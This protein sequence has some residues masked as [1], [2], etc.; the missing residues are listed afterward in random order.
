MK[1]EL[2]SIELFAGAGGLAIGLE[3]AGF[4]SKGVFEF[5]KHACATLRHNRPAWNVV[6]G[7]VSEVDF[8]PY[9]GVD[10]VVGGV[11]CQAFSYAGKR[12]GFGDTRG[13]LFWQFA[14]AIRETRPR[15]F[16]MENV[17]G[18]VSH[19]GGRTLKTMIAE[20]TKIGYEVCEPHILN[21]LHHSVPQKRERLILVGFLPGLG[22]SFSAPIPSDVRLTLRDTLKAGCLYPTDVPLSPGRSYPE[23]RRDVYAYVPPGG[24]WRNL[25]DG[26]REAFMGA[27]LNSGGGRTGMARRL[28]WDEPSLTLLTSPSQRQT[29][30]CHPDETRPFTVRESARIQ[31]FPDN[32]TFC[33]PVAAQYKQIGN[34]VPVALATAVGKQLSIS[35]GTPASGL[36]A[37][38]AS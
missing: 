18:L 14:R 34:A 36:Q 13:T 28:S 3:A 20:L 11:P 16:L 1:V 22:I 21:A 33:G 4:E 30:R 26:I 12:L 25:P 2:T 7:D 38:Q 17:R 35:L 27:S 5:D 10:L 24:C 19:D 15:A 29:E 9:R 37:G 6:E 8:T 31:T 23:K 32:W